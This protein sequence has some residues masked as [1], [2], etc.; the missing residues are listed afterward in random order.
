MED[1]SKIKKDIQQ[2]RQ[3][4]EAMPK[5]NYEN[6]SSED[7]K[8]NIFEI[9]NEAEKSSEDVAKINTI[10]NEIENRII[11]PISIRI[12]KSTRM[13]DV[14]AF[15]SILFGILGLWLAGKSS[16]D[17]FES[18]KNMNDKL[19]LITS[20][21]NNLSN[22]IQE[23]KTI[24]ELEISRIRLSYDNKIDSIL[25]SYNAKVTDQYNTKLYLYRDPVLKKMG[26][27]NENKE[28]VIQPQFEKANNFIGQIAI[29][30][31]NGRWGVINKLG[32]FILQPKYEELKIYKNYIFS[33]DNSNEIIYTSKGKYLGNV[34]SLLTWDDFQSA[35]ANS[36]I[37]DKDII[38]RVLQMYPNI[39]Q[40]M[41]E[42]KNMR[43][44][45]PEIGPVIHDKIV[46]IL[47]K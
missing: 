8:K 25:K 5:F 16:L 29:V 33:Q 21:Q 9:L 11:H 42:I 31:I 2:A 17:S 18:N 43:A 19:N 47:N 22:R 38:V 39:E 32:K 36:K 41:Q 7:I 20:I 44:T 24:N 1:I 14:Y 30:E 28:V 10:K 34:A 23:S 40:R 12:K 45:Y 13:N 15:I 27:Q 46:E 35:M 26:Y 6:I 37:Q 4:L 3:K